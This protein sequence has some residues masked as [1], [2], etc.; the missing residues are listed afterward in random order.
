MSVLMIARPRLPVV[1][2]Y[3]SVQHMNNLTQKKYMSSVVVKHGRGGRVSVSG[4]TVTVLGAT[5][6]I[7][8]Y[9]VQRLGRIGTQMVIPYRGDEMHFRHLR[10]LA[11]VGQIN[12]VV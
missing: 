12:F 3:A 11:D 10:P 4:H 6:Q 5:G 2:S 9:L 1:A 7:G 8:R